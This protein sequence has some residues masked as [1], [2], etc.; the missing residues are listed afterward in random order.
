MK[1]LL[2][3][4]LGILQKAL[5]SFFG[6]GSQTCIDSVQA[7]RGKKCKVPLNVLNLG[8]IDRTLTWDAPGP[9]QKC[10]GQD[11]VLFPIIE[12]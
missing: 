6:K 2:Y 5:P 4:C 9:N 7:L 10:T 8:L 12:F 3:T 1:Y 11:A